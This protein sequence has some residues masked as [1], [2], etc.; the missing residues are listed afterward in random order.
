M[1]GGKRQGRTEEWGQK[2]EEV[3]KRAVADRDKEAKR[4]GE[5]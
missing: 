1:E 3:E 2:E 4:E 5:L